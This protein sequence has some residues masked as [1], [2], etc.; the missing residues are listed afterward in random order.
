MNGILK[1]LLF[2]NRSEG[3]SGPLDFSL[4]STSAEMSFFRLAN[5]R[6]LRAESICLRS[7]S[8]ESASNFVTVILPKPTIGIWADLALCDSFR[9]GIFVGNS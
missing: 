5:F 7:R 3:K 6:E 9:S 4:P 2:G 1:T 8:G